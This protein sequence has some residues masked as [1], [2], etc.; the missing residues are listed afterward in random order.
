VRIKFK[1]TPNR[2]SI[3]DTNIKLNKSI[4]DLSLLILKKVIKNI[5]VGNN[6]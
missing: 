4:N 5:A 2:T 1:A 6:N 3:D